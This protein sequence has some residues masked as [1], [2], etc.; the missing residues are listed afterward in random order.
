MTSAIPMIFASEGVALRGAF[1]P[2]AD[3]AAA[4]V[5]VMA[6]GF[7]A[8]AEQLAAQASAFARAG[9]AAFVFDN[10]GFG[11]SGG[12]PRQEVDP[13]AQLRAYRDAVG[14]VRTLPAVDPERIALW[15]SSFS[16]G[17]V[18][19]A[20]ALDPRV[21]CIVSKAPFVSGSQLFAHW[22]HGP[23]LVQMTLAERRPAPA[24]PSRPCSRSWPPA[25]NPARC[26]GADGYDYFSRTGGATWKNEI[27]L[28]SL[29]M[30]RA[31]EPGWWIAHLAPRPLLM[32]VAE[33]DEVTPT[34]HALAA[35]DRAGEPGSWCASPAATSTSIGARASTSRSARRPRGSRRISARP[36]ARHRQT[37]VL[38]RAVARPEQYDRHRARTRLLRSRTAPQPR[39]KDETYAASSVSSW[40]SLLK[41]TR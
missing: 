28:S 8:V 25:T 3:R 39:A 33:D 23:A 30:A 31:H 11:L 12:F 21:A 36:P 18:L 6:H 13:V 38:G 7:S 15:G 10:P 19:Q 35:F 5:V 40:P 26:P 16:G 27:T 24:A 1:Y 22:P 9:F 4:P 37:A 34:D 17:H 14:Y 41:R 20:G 32:I 2:A 29:E